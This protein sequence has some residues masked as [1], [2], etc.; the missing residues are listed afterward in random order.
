MSYDH[1]CQY[2]LYCQYCVYCQ[3]VLWINVNIAPIPNVRHYK[4]SKWG[5]SWFW[6]RKHCKRHLFLLISEFIHIDK[7]NITTKKRRTRGRSPVCGRFSR[8]QLTSGWEVGGLGGTRG[9][10]FCFCKCS[11]LSK[12]CLGSTAGG[13][14]VWPR[15][16]EVTSWVV[17]SRAQNTNYCKTDSTARWLLSCWF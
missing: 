16:V 6:D 12:C 4:Y 7:K 11:H 10:R 5:R 8:K 9:G 15:T 17:R 1:L 2:C 14:F 13:N 3:D